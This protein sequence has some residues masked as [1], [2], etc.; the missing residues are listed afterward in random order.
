MVEMELR[1]LEEEISKEVARNMA[2]TE[3]EETGGQSGEK[4]AVVLPTFPPQSATQFTI[5]MPTK[6]ISIGSTIF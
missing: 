6:V 2:G 3:E 4:G 1:R 5:V